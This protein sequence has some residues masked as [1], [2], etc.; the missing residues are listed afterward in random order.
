VAG[1]SFFRA[2]EDKESIMQTIRKL[3]NEPIMRQ[4]FIFGSILG[5]I[6]VFYNLVNNLMN[7]DVVANA[8]LNNSMLVALVL[9]LGLA[10]F[11]TRK[12]KSGALAGFTAGLISALIGIT[13]MWIVTL[14]SMETISHNTFMIMDFQRSGAATMNQFI[15]ED[16]V[17]ATAVE[18]VVSLLFGAILG[19]L[20]GWLGSKTSTQRPAP[21]V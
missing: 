4:G 15:I 10:G 8:W 1:V 9:L 16:A 20:G 2:K 18:F 3:I 12:A 19:L 6:H 14:L 21:A 5:T 11:G 13:S 17:G 7:L